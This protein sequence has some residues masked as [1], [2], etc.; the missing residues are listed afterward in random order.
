MKRKHIFE[1]RVYLRGVLM[2]WSHQRVCVCVCVCVCCVFVCVGR[3]AHTRWDGLSMFSDYTES[4]FFFFGKKSRKYCWYSKYIR[5][6][7]KALAK[8]SLQLPVTVWDSTAVGFFFFFFNVVS[9]FY[10]Y[11]LCSVTVTKDFQIKKD[12]VIYQTWCWFTVCELHR[13]TS[14]GKVAKMSRNAT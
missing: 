12:W 4:L 1:V 5:G 2:S 11:F 14:Q 3:G 8:L 9:C 6:W 7:I 10:G 13:V